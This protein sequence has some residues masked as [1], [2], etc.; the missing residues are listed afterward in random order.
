MLMGFL[1]WVVPLDH[2][3]IDGIFP[4]KPSNYGGIPIYGHPH[5]NGFSSTR[6]YGFLHFSPSSLWSTLR[7]NEGTSP[8]FM[9]KSTN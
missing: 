1:K 9:G 2:P 6:I 5:F 7:K 4:S 8:L 3:F